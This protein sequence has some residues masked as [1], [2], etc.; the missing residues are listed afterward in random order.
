MYGGNGNLTFTADK[1]TINITNGTIAMYTNERCFSLF[2]DTADYLSCS[3]DSSHTAWSD[4]VLN[5]P[6]N[7]SIIMAGTN[8]GGDGSYMFYQPRG[9]FVD[10]NFNLYITDCVNDRIQVFASGQ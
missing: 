5:S 9:I 2:I 7:R 4:K 8:A 1:W 10:I 6:M 3:M